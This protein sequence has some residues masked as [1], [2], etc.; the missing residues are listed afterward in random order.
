MCRGDVLFVG[1]R[2]SSICTDCGQGSGVEP[3]SQDTTGRRFPPLMAHFLHSGGAPRLPG[4]ALFN[5]AFGDR[6]ARMGGESSG[7]C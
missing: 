4:P 1:R 2:G 7:W 6:R 5:L 3:V